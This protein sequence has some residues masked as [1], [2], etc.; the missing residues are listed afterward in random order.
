M[1]KMINLISARAEER[2][3]RKLIHTIRG[4]K[5]I[6]DRDLASLYDIE[7]RVLKQAVNRNKKRFP[8]DS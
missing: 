7:T 1:G 6:F 2:T 5:I 8:E 4:T 3:L